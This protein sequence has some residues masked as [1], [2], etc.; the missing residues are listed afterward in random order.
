MGGKVPLGYDVIDRKL[1]LNETEAPWVQE[2]FIS[3]L[4]LK[5][6]AKL[7]SY[8]KAKGITH[9]QTRNGFRIE[10]KPLTESV[11][12]GILKHPVYIG[13]THHRGELHDGQHEAMIEV[14]VWEEVKSL[15][16]LQA[17]SKD[18]RHN[19]SGLLLQGKLYD[20]DGKKYRCHF[21]EKP[22]KKRHHYYVSKDQNRLPAA[23]IETHILAALQH[24]K[25]LS[26]LKL[27]EE[28][29]GQW[30]KLL[31]HQPAEIIQPLIKKITIGKDATWIH[32]AIQD[33]ESLLPAAAHL[34]P[35]DLA[36]SDTLPELTITRKS[37]QLEI[38]LQQPFAEKNAIYANRATRHNE[39]LR[40]ALG[41]GFRWQQMLHDAPKLDQRELAKKE[42]VDYRYLTRVLH[43]MMLAPD[44]MTSILD[45]TQPADL[46]MATF[47][48]INMPICW[49]EQRKLLGFAS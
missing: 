7:L 42:G 37:D 39:A 2:I 41:Q 26:H 45:G 47:R 21:S 27:N 30:Q 17:R 48:T 8:L 10:D 29:Q 23:M 12:Y 32:L 22:T 35:A 49:N 6:V 31:C 34:P 38:Q 19:R 43:M 25:T 36:D 24:P 14:S 11:L 40:T 28:Q 9:K 33:L 4:R 1:V 5:S 46:S 3:Y 20:L 16:Q 44:I 13:K 15:I 18:G